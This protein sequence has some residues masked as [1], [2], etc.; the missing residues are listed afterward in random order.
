M[1][2]FVCNINFYSI[3]QLEI[4]DRKPTTSSEEGFLEREKIKRL[5][6]GGDQ[7]RVPAVIHNCFGQPRIQ[8]IY[9][10]PERKGELGINRRVDG[11]MKRM[12]KMAMR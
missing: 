12:G 6:L 9:Q 11:S 4:Y 7:N 8:E 1:I 3:L 5:R 2:H 10:Q